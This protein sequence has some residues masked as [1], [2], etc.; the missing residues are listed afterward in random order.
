MR[1]PLI[2]IF[3]L[4][5]VSALAQTQAEM[6]R[7]AY[8]AYAKADEEL[9]QVYQRIVK[10]YEADAAFISNLKASQRI[11]VS[12]RDAE[13]KLKFPDRAPGHYGSVHSICRAAYLDEITRDRTN[14]LKQWLSGV[15]EG[16][17]CAG[18]IR[19]KE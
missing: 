10:A 7:Q 12:F 16:D 8:T 4:M 13:L 3:S 15:E 14:K 9:N 17:V 19:L 2:L 1:L 18:S 5:A 11:W 6:S